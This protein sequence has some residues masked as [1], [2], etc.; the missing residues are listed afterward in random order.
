MQ[1]AIVGC[2]LFGESH[3]SALQALTD[4]Q[5]AAVYDVDEAK[6]RQFAERYSVTLVAASLGELIAAPV[7][8]VH[9]V[10][11]E[12]LHREPVVAAL[13]AGRHVL[14]EKPFATSVED[15]EAMIAAA[16]DS[17]GKLM[18]GHILRFD[19]R[20]GTMREQAHAGAFGRVVNVSAR[21]NRSRGGFAMYQRVHPGIC[22]SVH[23]IDL[24]LS[25]VKSRA[26][27]VRAFERNVHGYE[28]PDFFLGVMEFE[29]GA[30][31]EVQTSWL[32]PD[33]AGVGLDD[34]LQVIGDKGT[35]V[36]ALQPSP[37][38]LWTEAGHSAPD[39]GYETRLHGVAQGAL[40]NELAYFYRCVRTGCPPLAISPAEATNAVRVALAMLESA[41][42]GHDVAVEG[43]S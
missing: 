20:Y 14:V 23:D 7:D 1:A 43:W 6:A 3:A 34:Y 16:R 42:R 29:S 36:V 18:V 12:S 17:A 30:L 15:C 35:G 31:A 37:V 10:T 24:V 8:T 38:S 2:G 13:A 21:R 33:A 4:V 41:K 25:I 19:L 39:T 40:L 9:V 11:P 22:N 5:L 32:L 27:R 26:V 28:N